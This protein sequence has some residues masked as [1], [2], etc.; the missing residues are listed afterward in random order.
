MLSGFVLR[1]GAR[2][3]VAWGVLGHANLDVTQNVY[4]RKVGENVACYRK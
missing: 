4:G 2:L 1:L 3:E